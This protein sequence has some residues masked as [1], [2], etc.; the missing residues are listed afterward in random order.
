MLGK[1]RPRSLNRQEGLGGMGMM[2]MAV[3]GLA[4]CLN[5]TAA[6]RSDPVFLL[7]L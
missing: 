6:R 1:G 4:G 7:V 3:G 2:A 5:S